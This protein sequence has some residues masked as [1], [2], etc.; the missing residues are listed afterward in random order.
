M[1]TVKN[2]IVLYSLAMSCFYAG[3]TAAQEVKK[4]T[5][6]E[7]VTYA[8]ENNLAVA[9]AELLSDRAELTYKQSH[10]EL[11]P[12][13]NASGSYSLNYGRN[14]DPFTNSITTE[15]SQFSRASI[16]AG[17]TLFSGIRL[18][19]TIKQN[20]LLFE[21]SKLDYENTRD[22]VSLDVVTFYLNVIFNKELLE[23]AREQRTSTEQQ[24]N[25]TRQMVEAGSLPLSNQLDLEA[26]LAGDESNFIKAENSLRMS[27]LTLKQQLQIPAN[28]PFDIVVPE[29]NME[30]YAAVSQ[31][32]ND[33][34]DAALQTRPNIR[35]AELNLESSIMGEKIAK[36]G[37]YPTVSAG[38]SL[39]SNYSSLAEEFIGLTP[40]VDTLGYLFSNTNEFVATEF[41]RQNFNSDYPYLDQMIDNRNGSLFVSVNIPIFNAFR[42]R[43]SVQQAAVNRS[44]AEISLQETRNQLRQIIE[45]AYNDAIAAD[46]SYEAAEKQVAALKEAFRVNEQRYEVGAVNFTEYQVSKNNLNRAENDLVRAKFDYIFRLKIVDFYLGNPLTI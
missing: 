8:L 19:N 11:L 20:K 42:Q 46:K 2:L 14:V 12:N 31:E 27:I 32:V 9:R 28:E 44:L 45:T 34:Y 23:N 33:I 43:T 30:G 26:Q 37:L 39:G 6:E 29:L 25:R 10:Y 5:L 7:C 15:Q 3:T 35:S 21:S 18:R 40:A 13:L 1:K 4:W 22:N 36:G 24:L 16:S 38:Y 17:V 41:F